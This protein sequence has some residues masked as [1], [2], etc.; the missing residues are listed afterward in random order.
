[1]ATR[2]IILPHPL[3]VGEP[4]PDWGRAPDV[5]VRVAEPEDEYYSAAEVRAFNAVPVVPLRPRPKRVPKPKRVDTPRRDTSTDD[6]DPHPSEMPG[7][8]IRRSRE[9]LKTSHRGDLEQIELQSYFREPKWVR[10]IRRK[11][12]DHWR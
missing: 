7:G 3:D 11:N 5:P 8:L 9:R 4:A 2:P 12:Y 10:M 6:L 1:M